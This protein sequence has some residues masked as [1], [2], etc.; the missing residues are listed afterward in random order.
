MGLRPSHAGAPGGR[1]ARRKSPAALRTSGQA[2]NLA[3]AKLV[4]SKQ[5]DATSLRACYR[6]VGSCSVFCD[7]PVGSSTPDQYTRYVARGEGAGKDKVAWLPAPLENQ[8]KPGKQSD[9]GPSTEPT[10]S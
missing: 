6:G 4:E 7:R 5:G 1:R 8:T 3:E 9:G 2:E 10:W